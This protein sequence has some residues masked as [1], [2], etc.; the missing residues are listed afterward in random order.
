M[1]A[2]A[3]SATLNIDTLTQVGQAFQPRDASEKLAALGLSA[4]TRLYSIALPLL[5]AAS[6]LAMLVACWRDLSGQRPNILLLAAASAW[7]LVAC[8]VGLIALF[9]VNSFPDPEPRLTAPGTY[10][11]IVAAILALAAYYRPSAPKALVKIPVSPYS[12]VP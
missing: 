11:A 9:N 7:V 2:S 8:R 6:L 5:M 10:M 3:D 1:S 12:G 4:L